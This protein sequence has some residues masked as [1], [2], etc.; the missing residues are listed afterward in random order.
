MCLRLEK[1][2]RYASIKQKNTQMLK[3]IEKWT[4]IIR[5][6]RKYT[7]NEFERVKVEV[8]GQSNDKMKLKLL[9]EVKT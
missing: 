7:L 1:S 4:F 2:R 6:K 5:T 9:D 8:E 3:R